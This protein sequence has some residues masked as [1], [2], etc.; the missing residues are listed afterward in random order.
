MNLAHDVRHAIR[1]LR[2][3]RV[4]TFI[5][6][7]T[8]ALGIGANA[9]VFAVTHAVL[10]RPLPWA[11][12][13]RL[14][15]LWSS[16][17]ARGLAQFSISPADYMTWRQESRV[18]EGLAAFDR[19]RSAVLSGEGRQPEEVVIAPASA[20]LF[21]LIG[22][23]PELGRTFTTGEASPGGDNVAVLTD[24]FWRSALAGD[25]GVLGRSIS[26]DGTLHTIV[27]VMP[28]EFVV[29]GNDAQVWTPLRLEEN[30]DRSLRFLRVFG[31]LK[32]GFQV[33]DA[34]ADLGAV[35]ER[36]SQAFPVTNGGW[37]ITIRP[38]NE[39][40]VG[41]V[42]RRAVIVLLGVVA[43][44]LL[45]ACANISNLMLT[46]AAARRQEVAVRLALGASRSR[47]IREWLTEGAVLGAAAGVLGVMLGSWGVEL[48]RAI[49][50][51]RVPRLDEVGVN[52]VVVAFTF[53]VSMAAGLL[54]AV[55]PALHAV[56][57]QLSSSLKEGGRGLS[58][59]RSTRRT[60]STLLVLQVTV[61]IMLLVGAGLLLESAWRL[62]RVELGFE[63]DN[64]LVAPVALPEARYGDAAAATAFY[65]D[66]LGRAAALP[67]VQA[68]SAVSSAPFA[69]PN[70]GNLFVRE[71]H[72]V[73]RREDAPDTDYRVVT[74][75]YFG[76]LGIPIRR[77]RD[78]TEADGAGP[79]VTII[80]ESFARLFF[81]DVDPIGHRIRLGDIANGVWRTVI[82]VAG[83][84]RYQSVEA[85][86]VRP[87][88]YVPPMQVRQP[89]P[90]AMMLV[91]RSD[92]DPAALSAA[93][94]AEIGRMDAQLAP[95]TLALLDDVVGF[96]YAQ[97]RFQLVLFT[98]FA[99][100]ALALAAVGVYGVT[101]YTVTQRRRE[102]GVRI[103]LGA[104]AKHLRR[105]VVAQGVGLAFV[106]V[107]GGVIASLVLTR[108]MQALL[109][110][111]DPRNP[112]VFLGVA[113]LLLIMAAAASYVPARRATRIDPLRALRDAS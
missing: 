65:R 49:G 89:S 67:G 22:I 72:E 57:A 63:P 10:I 110:D 31:R 93:L 100:L 96:A 68:A 52:G 47:V 26:L 105:L 111:T 40:V 39:V 58:A 62:H 30:G 11:E 13:D 18:F 75:G 60:R 19:Q 6:V 5:A 102:L 29:P 77:G 24:G 17:P 48:L 80:S 1:S 84:A 99:A 53:T 4:F 59:G 103:A 113:V 90:R 45:I 98:V 37:S 25:A 9:A 71:G 14:V 94:R 106:G 21:P 38:L 76:T 74:P 88:M 70:S 55:A 87:M 91:L 108:F 109:F 34:I 79:E 73:A 16:N 81:A 86:E 15:R 104:Q 83:D 36:L 51:N 33:E 28:P 95:G 20:E 7:V 2:N 82:G 112:A 46:R 61:A 54:L 3:S 66:L 85:P 32:P 35:T 27:G 42:F 56:N 64:V 43:A 8:L 12:P 69:G 50:A 97:Q 78:F 107:A 44:V 23:A 101:A 41:P 92:A